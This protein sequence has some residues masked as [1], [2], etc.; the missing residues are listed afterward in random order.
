MKAYQKSNAKGVIRNGEYNSPT[1]RFS[2]KN[3]IR[4]F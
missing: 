3:I 1:K 4:F 2:S